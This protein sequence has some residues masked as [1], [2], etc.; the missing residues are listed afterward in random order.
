MV[1]DI[2]QSKSEIVLMKERV[3][4]LVDKLELN[5]SS[6]M[7]DLTRQYNDAKRLLD[8]AVVERGDP[9]EKTRKNQAL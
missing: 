2:Q 9:A 4:S 5:H 3:N 7:A 8:E 6:S 1:R